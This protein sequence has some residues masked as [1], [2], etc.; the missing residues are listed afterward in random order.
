MRTLIVEDEFTSRMLLQKMLERYGEC[1]VAVNGRE[2]VEAVA[3][4]LM[5]GTPYD[6]ICLDIMMPEMDG[7]E[8][9]RAIRQLEKRSGIG[10][11]DGVRIVMTTA[12]GDKDNIM[13]AFR[14]QCDGYLVKPVDKNKLTRLM[15]DIGL[16][17][18]A[19][20][21]GR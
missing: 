11:L 3:A 14:E 7:Q 16:S 9:L 13:Q 15:D 4:A 21:T 8:T 10:G 6:L 5:V 18:L 2:A 17:A 12:L 20:E 19:D 1:H